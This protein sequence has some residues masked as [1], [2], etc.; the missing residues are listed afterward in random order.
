MLFDLGLLSQT[1]CFFRSK[2]WYGVEDFNR[3]RNAM[4]FGADSASKYLGEL[5][6]NYVKRGNENE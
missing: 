6:I 3:P 5:I 2:I 1:T 4:V